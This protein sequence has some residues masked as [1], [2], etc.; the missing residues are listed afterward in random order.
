MKHFRLPR[1]RLNE[2]NV[3]R[4]AIKGADYRQRSPDENR[5]RK[6]NYMKFSKTYTGLLMGMILLLAAGAEAASKGSLVL[7]KAV[8]INGTPLAKG[9]YK[10]TWEGTGPNIELNVIQSRKIV[11]TVPARLVDLDR[12]GQQ[13]GYETRMQEDGTTSLTAIFFLGKRYEMQ[14]GPESAAAEPMKDS[15][16]Q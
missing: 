9:E 8:S 5:R 6:G 1:I 12:A 14:I 15:N 10:L 11:A 4:P 16:Q 3:N 7:D 2:P 13:M